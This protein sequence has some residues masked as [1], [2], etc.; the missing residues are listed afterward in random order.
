MSTKKNSSAKAEPTPFEAFKL[1]RLVVSSANYDFYK[2]HLMGEPGGGVS[3]TVPG[4]A[5]GLEEILQKFSQGMPL[6]GLIK[7]GSYT[8]DE[9]IPNFRA[10]DIEEIRQY[11]QDIDETIQSQIAAMDAAT[12]ELAIRDGVL[13][14][15]INN[16][17][18]LPKEPEPPVPPAPTEPSDPSANT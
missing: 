8:E 6:D 16:L 3:Q 9:Y 1:T 17:V 13:P 11:R 5:M 14:P 15:D 10:M 12:R 18:P 2:D 4:G 7:E